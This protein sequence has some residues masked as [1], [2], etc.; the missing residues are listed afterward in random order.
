[1][2]AVAKTGADEAA[3]MVITKQLAYENANTACQAAIRPY[4]KRGHLTDFIRLCSDIGPSYMQAAYMAAMM[5]GKPVQEVISQQ[6]QS[7]R[8]GRARWK[9][10]AA[11]ACFACGQPGHHAARCP[12]RNGRPPF[13]QGPSAVCSRCGKGKHWAQNCQS[14]FDVKGKPLPPQGNW[15]RGQP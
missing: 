7:G 10:G 14:K 12:Q 15:V 11:G 9:A 13:R 5:Q 4:K 8:G 3:S 2:E 1:M 6:R